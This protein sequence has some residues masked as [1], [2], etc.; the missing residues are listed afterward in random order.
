MTQSNPF[1]NLVTRFG[2]DKLDQVLSTF[3]C[4]YHYDAIRAVCMGTSVPLSEKLQELLLPQ[5]TKILEEGN[6][7]NRP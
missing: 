6:H 2:Q 1:K 4:E 3:E 5:V 7:V